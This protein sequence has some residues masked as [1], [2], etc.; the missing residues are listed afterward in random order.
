MEKIATVL[1]YDEEA[2][3]YA[4][5]RDNLNN[6]LHK[7]YFKS[8]ENKYSTSSQLDLSYPMLVGV[9]PQDIYPKV[10]DK[11]FTET[12]QKQNG[13]IG[14]G[15][16]G[17]PILTKWAIQ[18][19]A[20]DYMYTMLKKRDYPGYL[21]MID[22]GASTTWEY[23]S[24]ERSRIH[25][26]YNGIGSWFYQAV[27]GI[28]TDEDKPGYR[29]VYIDPQI[30]NGVTWAKTTKES[31]YGTISVNWKLNADKLN[32]AVTIPVG[33]SGTVILPPN[34]KSYKLNGKNQKISGES[35]TVENGSYDIEI[36][37]N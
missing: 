19:R 37:L 34:T 9:T 25:N 21:Y 33:S 20:V 28:R 13:H 4:V 23:W 12:A 7:T 29:H 11:L 3:E 32:M 36:T 26:C 5:R 10:K 15:L 1:G 31:P 22:N 8:E 14:C 17:V 30:P 27:G 6:L 35:F 24:G 2:K 18:N 16:V